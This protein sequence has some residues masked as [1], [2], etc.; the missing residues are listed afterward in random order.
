MRDG[1]ACGLCDFR[2]RWSSTLRS[3]L[4]HK[5]LRLLYRIDHPATDSRYRRTAAN[6]LWICTDSGAGKNE[7]PKDSFSSEALA[8]NKIA[9]W[10]P[11]VGT[12][13]R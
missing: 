13:G 3:P 4:F 7:P 8:R 10:V 2:N 11:V 12:G 1:D 5:S 9:K 6:F